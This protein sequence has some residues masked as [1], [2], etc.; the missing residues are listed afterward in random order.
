MRAL[1][2]WVAALPGCRV[3]EAPDR[4]E[5]LVVYGFVHFDEE[6]PAYLQAMADNLIPAAEQHLEALAEGYHVDALTAGDLAA[7]G[8]AADVTS[9]IGALGRASYTHALDD[10]LCGVTWPDKAEVFD[11]YVSYEIL[12]E[13]GDRGCF[14]EGACDRYGFRA[15]Q[16]V[17][18]TLLGASTQELEVGF[19]HVARADGEPVVVSRVLAPDPIEFS[20]SLLAVD[21][22]YALVVLVPEG[23]G[24][25]RLEA[26]WVD[27]SMVDVDMPEYFAVNMAV[28]EMQDQADRVDAF[29]AEGSCR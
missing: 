17:E 27:A 1:L 7:V 11:A 16:T 20:T 28:G 3:V 12:E 13:E 5:E 18:V 19:R 24:T 14:L 15:R 10:V 25:R 6:D 2:T 29:L 8:I 4:L 26:F 21:Q 23:A 9:I 22:Q